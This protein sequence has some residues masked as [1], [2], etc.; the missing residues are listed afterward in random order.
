MSTRFTPPWLEGPPP[1]GSWRAL[2]KWGAPEQTR[3][4]GLRLYHLLKQVCS[5]DISAR[6]DMPCRWLRDHLPWCPR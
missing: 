6:I 5:L 4:P 3:H 1:P 2:F